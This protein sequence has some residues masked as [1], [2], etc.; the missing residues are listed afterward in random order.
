MEER[1]RRRENKKKETEKERGERREGKGKRYISDDVAVLHALLAVQRLHLDVLQRTQARVVRL[2]D[3]AHLHHG[4]TVQ[5]R[6]QPELGHSLHRIVPGGTP[7]ALLRTLGRHEPGQLLRARLAL[8]VQHFGALGRTGHGQ[9]DDDQGW[10]RKE[11]RKRGKG[12]RERKE[13]RS[14]GKKG[15]LFDERAQQFLVLRLKCGDLLLHL[16]L[17]RRLAFLCGDGDGVDDDIDGDNIIGD[18]VDCDGN[19]GDG[20]IGDDNI[21]CDVGDDDAVSTAARAAWRG[22][23]GSAEGCIRAGSRARTRAPSAWR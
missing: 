18:D 8:P 7:R 19:I 1:T 22:V 5:Q 13:E 23:R 15:Y 4:R 17:A 9:A 16:D 20:N 14:G 3:L 11:R 21:D 2:H 10:R 12:E 6:V